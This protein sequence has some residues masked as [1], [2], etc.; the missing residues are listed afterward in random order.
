MYV[1]PL[2][3]TKWVINGNCN[4]SN[5][6]SNS[7]LNYCNRAIILV[8]QLFSNDNNKYNNSKAISGMAVGL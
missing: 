6:C 2:A 3:H 1:G 7:D 8:Q 5:N 4:N